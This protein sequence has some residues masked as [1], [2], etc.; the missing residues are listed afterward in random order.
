MGSQLRSLGVGVVG[1][2]EVSKVSWVEGKAW[3]LITAALRFKMVW[4]LWWSW[5]LLEDFSS[6]RSCLAKGA[7]FASPQQSYEYSC[8]SLTN[9]DTP[10]TSMHPLF[11]LSLH[12]ILQPAIPSATIFLFPMRVN[13]NLNF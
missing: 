1:S 10:H 9:T 4:S 2:W 11:A 6:S 7:W 8:P 3:L 5:P 13:F 12:T